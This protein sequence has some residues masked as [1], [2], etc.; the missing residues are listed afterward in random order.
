MLRASKMTRLARTRTIRLSDGFYLREE[1]LRILF[2]SYYFPPYNII[3]SLR[4]GK[5]AKYLRQFGHE[6]RIVTA[7][8]LPYPADLPF[9]V[10][11]EHVIATPWVDVS[12]PH[13]LATRLRRHRSGVVALFDKAPAGQMQYTIA[14]RLLDAY[15]ALVAFPDDAIGWFPF[16][17]NA[18]QR[19]L[20][21]WRPDVL[22]ASSGPPTSLLI[23]NAL[24]QQYNLP[25]VGELRDLWTD[26]HYYSYPMWRRV[27]E[28]WLERRTLRTAAGLVTV[29]EPLAHALRLRYNLP[30]EVVLNGF[31]PA[32]Y[33]P[34]RPTRA[35]PQLTI[36]YTGTIYRINQRAAPL[37]AALQ[38]L[39]ARAA[40]VR[41]TVYSHSI[42]GIVAIRSE[43]QQYGVEH[44]LDVRDAVPHREA[45]AQQRAADVLLLLLWNDPRER[46]V[47]TGKLF[48]YLGA[49][50][51]I[52]GIGPADN[53]AADLIRERRAGMVSADPVEIAGQ[54]TRWLDAKECGGIPDLPASASA[55]LSREEQTRRLERFLGQVIDRY[56]ISSDT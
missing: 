21:R 17:W 1:A 48:E 35:D 19:L 3:A 37:F 42:S 36:V 46:G 30:T 14:L 52:L 56:N 55:G 20:K 39:G 9:E 32:D 50:R 49:R 28:T 31:D 2:I 47:Y 26:N 6:V 24:H 40:R 23:A 11:S 12:M 38:R 8:N 41:V 27:L 33:P 25:W 34:M 18:A 16:G 45:L 7:R 22:V 43:A 44:L 53:V 51:P 10:P 29:S 13:T 4:V 5:T 15:R 54:L